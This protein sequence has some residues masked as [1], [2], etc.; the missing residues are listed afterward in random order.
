VVLQT[1]SP[2][3]PVPFMQRCTRRLKRTSLGFHFHAYQHGD[4]SHPQDICRCDVSVFSVYFLLM[5]VF[6]TSLGYFVFG[7]SENSQLG[8]FV[9]DCNQKRHQA[10]NLQVFSLSLL[11]RQ[12]KEYSA[13]KY[14]NNPTRLVYFPN[15]P[16]ERINKSLILR[17]RKP[18]S[19]AAHDILLN[20][21]F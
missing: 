11:N 15:I 16:G 18:L 14:F 6:L 9:N 3:F 8:T 5:S 7:W 17:F 2:P 4:I 12:N 20:L 10:C 21:S 1:S 19:Q 13:G